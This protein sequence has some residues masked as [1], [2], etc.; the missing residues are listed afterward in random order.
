MSCWSKEQLKNMK[1]HKEAKIIYD[2]QVF[3]ARRKTDGKYFVPV[4]MD[5]FREELSFYFDKEVICPCVIIQ[6]LSK[7]SVDLLLDYEFVK[8]EEL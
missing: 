4:V 5:D 6:G 7:K 1:E 3:Y 8:G 2:G